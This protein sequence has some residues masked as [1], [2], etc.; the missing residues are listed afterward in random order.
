VRTSEI[1]YARI[2][3][4]SIAYR[5]IDGSRG[6]DRDVVLVGSGTMSME[7]FFEDTV[8][9]RVLEG[10][11]DLGRL[12]VFDRRGIGLSDAPASSEGPG[13]GRWCDDVEAVVQAAEVH[14]PVLVGSLGS[15]APLVVFCNRH[16]A[17]VAAAVVVEPTLWRYGREFIDQQISGAIDSLSWIAPSRADEPG[18]REWFVRAGQTGASPS[19][20]ARSYLVP[21]AD[22]IRAL[23]DAAARMAV[24]FLVLRRPA[25]P[26]SPPADQDAVAALVRGAERIEIPGR[27]LAMYGNEAGAMLAEISRFI[28]GEHLLPEAE[29]VLAAVL[30]SDVVGSTEQASAMGDTRWA[31]L[32]DR[33]D[34][35]ARS[36]VGRRGGR[37]VKFE[38]DAVMAVFP[39]AGEAVRCGLDLIAAVADVGLQIRV[40]IHAGDV[41]RRG[42]DLSGMAVNIAARISAA[43]VTGEVLVSETVPRLVT[44]ASLTFVDRGEHTLKGVPEP[45]R[46]FAAVP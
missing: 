26:F 21:D 37:V 27:D 19:A 39:S 24:P 2:G 16:P 6:G 8:C 25:H 33:H 43:A 17:D 18:F 29:R 42:D 3:D 13:S 9:V 20:A 30:F 32:L 15:L 10:L 1:R 41:D 34:A 5:V 22:E 38:G 28:T 36:C 35:L 11:S 46:L 31:R 23:E 45:W 40:G 12:I 7:A 14:Q 4:D 44:G